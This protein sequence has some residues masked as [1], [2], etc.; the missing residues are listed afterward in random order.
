[1]TI[2]L[3]KEPVD[4]GCSWVIE[5]CHF[6]NLP[7]R[8]WHINTNNPCCP[9]CAKKHKVAELPDYGQGIRAAKR[10]LSELDKHLSAN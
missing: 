6:C 1:M 5:S 8:Y 7:T 4:M 3:M 9:V 2:P 10:K